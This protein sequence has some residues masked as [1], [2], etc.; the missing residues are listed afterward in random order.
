MEQFTIKDLERLSGVKAHT[1]RVWERRYRII[2]PMRTGT[3][4]RRYTGNDLRRLIN[5]S[6]LLRNGFKISKI[7]ALTEKETEEKA[8]AVLSGTTQGIAELDSLILAMLDLNDR[9]VNDILM[10][11]V[12]NRGFEETITDVVFPF[13]SRIGTMWQTGTISPGYE[14]FMTALFRNRMISAIDTL[15]GAPS[16]KPRRALLFLPENELHEMPL[17]FFT[18]VI[19]K[20]G[21][22]TLYLGQMTPLSSVVPI[23]DKWNPEFVITGTVTGLPEQPGEYLKQLASSFPGRRILVAG[24]LAT[25]AA[26]SRIKEIIAVTSVQ[27]LKTNMSASSSSEQL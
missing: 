26:R 5:I 7:A 16:S 25:V 24:T 13:M 8:A 1:L 17:L 2:K 18:W 12:M 22:E 9:Q 23:C 19:K 20:L 27:E 10:K 21:F 6:I 11:S 4:R 14:H 15:S 3:N